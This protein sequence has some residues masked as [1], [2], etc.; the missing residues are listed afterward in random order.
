MKFSN[1]INKRVNKMQRDL[2]PCICRNCCP[3]IVDGA[4]EYFAA[5]C[6]GIGKVNKVFTPEAVRRGRQHTAGAKSP[7]NWFQEVL[8]R[9]FFCCSTCKGFQY[10]YC[11]EDLE[12]GRLERDVRL[13]WE[14]KK[15]PCPGMHQL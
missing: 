14:K 11:C 9:K 12:V 10:V 7:C 6:Y 2:L 15:Y 13:I 5:V 4:L 3:G 1:N 8:I